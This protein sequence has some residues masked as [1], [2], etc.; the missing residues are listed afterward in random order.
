[1]PAVGRCRGFSLV[2]ILIVLAIIAG[3]TGLLVS[4][5]DGIFGSSREQIVRIFV[6]EIVKAPLMAYKVN[7]GNYPSTA[8]GLKALIEAPLD[9]EHRWKGPYME[10]LPKD[11]WGN[12]YCYACPGAHNGAKYD[13]WSRGSPGKNEEI[14]N[15]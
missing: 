4:N 15:W 9:E 2:E 11:P 13:V 7:V 5:L 14:G 8:D 12:D 10:S 1:M 6:N 3:I